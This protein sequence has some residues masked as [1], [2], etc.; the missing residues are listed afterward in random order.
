MVQKVKDIRE[1]KYTYD[2]ILKYAEDKERFL[3]MIEN[4]LNDLD[5]EKIEKLYKE[6]YFE[7]QNDKLD[8][9]NKNI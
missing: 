3:S 5:L 6:L 2:E 4:N 9:S 7:N 1:G 8:L